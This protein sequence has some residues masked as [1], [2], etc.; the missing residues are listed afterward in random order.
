MSDANFVAAPVPNE[1]AKYSGNDEADFTSAIRHLTNEKTNPG[2]SSERNHPVS[3]TQRE[4]P[5]QYNQA[6]R[7][8]PLKQI[9][10]NQDSLYKYISWE[11]P[12][13]TL[14]SYIGALCILFGTHYLPLTQYVLKGGVTI[15]GV[16]SVTEFASRSFGS[17]SL[18][19]RLRP[20]EYKRVPE[21]TLNATL[22]D[23]HDFIQYAV[24]KAQ[25]IVFGQDLDR[26]F[27]ACIGLAVLF[28]LNKVVTPFW[29]AVIGLTSIYITP[30]VRSPQ[31]RAVAQNAGVRAQ[32]LASAATEHGKVLVEDGK[33]KA[34]ELSAKTRDAAS[35]HSGAATDNVKGLS[36]SGKN[37][38]N[39]AAGS[40]SSTLS[41]AKQSIG[42]SLPSSITGQSNG[43]RSVGSG[44]ADKTSQPSNG[45]SENVRQLGSGSHTDR[46]YDHSENVLPSYAGRAG[47]EKVGS[48]LQS[49][50]IYAD[51][52]D[53]TG[54]QSIM[55]RPR[56]T[57]LPSLNEI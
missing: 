7:S 8:G 4:Q 53:T 20:K 11:D 27:G 32:E 26:T 49:Q 35:N 54:A 51:E 52:E 44:I 46:Q 9:I 16:V 57:T 56:G 42:S 33:T 36:Q 31:G 50:S 28:W 38:V 23:V 18:S 6:E 14:G 39:N 24:V 1:G 19:T 48:Q 45:A 3:L 10:A 29:L 41:D 22:K 43:D 21:A 25:R 2:Q 15:L 13:R 37:A 47:G 40:T 17:N 5:N 12:I 55:D 34:A 30:L